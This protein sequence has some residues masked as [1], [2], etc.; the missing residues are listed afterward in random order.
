MEQGDGGNSLSLQNFAVLPGSGNANSISSMAGLGGDSTDPLGDKAAA[1]A[2]LQQQYEALRNQ[3][4][5]ADQ[6][7]DRLDQQTQQGLGYI[8]QYGQSGADAMRAGEASALSSLSAGEQAGMGAINRGADSSLGALAQGYGQGRGDLSSGFGQGRQDLAGGYGA[9]Q[10]SLGQLAGMGAVGTYDVTG[11]Q[12]RTGRML[13]QQGGL[14]GGFQS[15]PGYQ[16]RQQQ[17]EDAINRAA[18]ARGGRLSGRT[19]QELGEFN[20]GLASQ[21]YGNFAARRQA[22]AGVAAGSDAQRASLLTNQA[23]RADASQLAAQGYRA[24]GLGDL[25]QLGMQYGQSQAGL[26]TGLGQGLSGLSTG[27][28]QSQSGIYGSQGTQLAGLNQWGAGGRADVSQ[29]TGQ[30]L[31]DLWAG[32]GSNMAD[33]ST[34]N[35]AIGAGLS[36]TQMEGWNDFAS[37]GNSAAEAESGNR[38]NILSTLLAAFSDLRLKANVKP[39]EGS[40]YERIGLR[41]YSWTWN[42]K[43][44]DLLG[45]AGD[46]RGVMAHEVRVLYP[47]AVRRDQSGYLQVD[48]SALDRM[49]SEAA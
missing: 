32:V 10:G 31:G 16:F 41:G 28:G 49:I 11:A 29:Q 25:G 18:S 30:N 3:G 26:S 44:G 35:S 8:S 19:M 13:D 14:Y 17:G 4:L 43:A 39:I 24:Q 37:G 47:A 5:I 46:S 21:E 22:E 38:K 40:K 33:T 42:K 12:D 48:Y 9:A 36:Q 15:D 2:R 1:E 27:L 45:L 23:G 6:A 20:Q 7:R 34:A